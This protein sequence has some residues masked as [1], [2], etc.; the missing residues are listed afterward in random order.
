MALRNL[1]YTNLSLRAKNM[2]ARSVGR[3]WPK[4]V[5]HTVRVICRVN[6]K[7][8]MMEESFIVQPLILSCRREELEGSFAAFGFERGK[9]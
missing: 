6:V 4:A 5:T 8:V 3:P 1:L 2:A 7:T 9:V